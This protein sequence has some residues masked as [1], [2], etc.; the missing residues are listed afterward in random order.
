MLGQRH[1]FFIRF[2]RIIESLHPQSLLAGLDGRLHRFLSP[3]G[4]V[5]HAHTV[6]EIRRLGRFPI[7]FQ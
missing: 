4:G 6:L 7:G 3:G 1:R 5:Q 2:L